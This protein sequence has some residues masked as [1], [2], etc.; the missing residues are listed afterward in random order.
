VVGTFE[1]FAHDA[2]G[3]EFNLPVGAAVFQG[4]DFT[5]AISIYDDRLIPEG[6]T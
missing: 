6:N 1:L 4:V 5:G 3:T 2:T